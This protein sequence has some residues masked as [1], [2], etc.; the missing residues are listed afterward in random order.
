[1]HNV[2]HCNED[3]WEVVNLIPDLSYMDDIKISQSLLL[4]QRFEET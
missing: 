3:A 1:M 2:R 4:A